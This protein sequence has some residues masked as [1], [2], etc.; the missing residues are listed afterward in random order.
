MNYLKEFG[1][2]L[3]WQLE[4]KVD[5]ARYWDNAKKVADKEQSEWRLELSYSEE[6]SL[7]G[8]TSQVYIGYKLLLIFN[9]DV[10][11]FLLSN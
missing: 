8:L 6:I 10:G 9:P 11:C 7:M 2:E 4:P 1:N 3:R 5:K